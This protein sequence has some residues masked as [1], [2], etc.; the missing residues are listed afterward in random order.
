MKKLILILSI[1]V[2]GCETTTS[3]NNQWTF[4]ATDGSYIQW[5][6]D[7]TNAYEMLHH[8]MKHMYNVEYE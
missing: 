3:T 4:D 2:L 5:N 8:A 1:L 6:G 7:K